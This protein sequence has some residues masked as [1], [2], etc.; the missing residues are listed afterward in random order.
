MEDISSLVDGGTMTVFT[1]QNV[2]Q[3]VYLEAGV[4]GEVD[5]EHKH[6]KAVLILCS[7]K[8]KKWLSVCF[9]QTFCFQ[10]LQS[11]FGDILSHGP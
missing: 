4:Y 8:K 2:I 10:H 7:F 3:D 9:S 11:G 5:K 6:L 1:P